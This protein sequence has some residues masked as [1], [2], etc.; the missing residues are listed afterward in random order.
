MGITYFGVVTN[1]VEET[2]KFLYFIVC[3]CTFCFVYIDQ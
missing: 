1:Q 3:N 2:F